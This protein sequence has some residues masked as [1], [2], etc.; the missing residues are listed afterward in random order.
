MGNL[1]TSTLPWSGVGWVGCRRLG[2]LTGSRDGTQ[3]RASVGTPILLGPSRGKGST[4][5]AVQGGGLLILS[6]V[7]WH[8]VAT[9]NHKTE[10]FTLLDEDAHE[11]GV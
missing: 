5:W 11:M 4:G 7:Y 10:T 3:C 2:A 6:F 8:V 1:T 9:K